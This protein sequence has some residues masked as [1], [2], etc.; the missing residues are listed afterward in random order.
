MSQKQQKAMGSVA[1]RQKPACLGEPSGVSFPFAPPAMPRKPPAVSSPS[2]ASMRSSPEKS[3]PSG[4]SASP[5]VISSMTLPAAM[6]SAMT[7]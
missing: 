1:A 6:M 5:A 7:R 4:A 3:M 2:S